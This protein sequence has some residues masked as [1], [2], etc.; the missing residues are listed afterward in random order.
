MSQ[1][2]EERI[3]QKSIEKGIAHGY[4]TIGQ[5]LKENGNEKIIKSKL[6]NK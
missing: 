1:K 2:K 4:W 3:K 6:S 5:L